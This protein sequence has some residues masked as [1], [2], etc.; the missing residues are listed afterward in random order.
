MSDV[1]EVMQAVAAYGLHADAQRWTELVGLFAPIV[2]VDY[3]ALQGGEP[4]V[5]PA[6]DLVESWTSFLPGFTGT[7]HLIGAPLV[8]I[9]GDVAEAEAAFTASHIVVDPIAGERQW[10]V[11]GRYQFGL[12]RHDGRWRIASVKLVPVWQS[13]DRKLPEVAAARGPL[14][15][16]TWVANTGQRELEVSCDDPV[17]PGITARTVRLAGNRV[18][19]SGQRLSGRMGRGGQVRHFQRPRMQSSA[20]WV[21]HRARPSRPFKLQ[22]VALPA[23]GKSAAETAETGRPDR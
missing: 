21:L 18:G 9:N 17:R 3:A 13:G 19:R 5:I 8:S 15:S 7:S 2:R 12:A 23:S 6:E 11:G 20:R 22:T 4:L 14:L 1:V 16:T 10:A